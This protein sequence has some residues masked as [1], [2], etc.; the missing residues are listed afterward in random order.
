MLNAL[1]NDYPQ[2]LAASMDGMKEPLGEQRAELDKR[3]K[4]IEEWLVALKTGK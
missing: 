3:S 2:A 1:A 4:K